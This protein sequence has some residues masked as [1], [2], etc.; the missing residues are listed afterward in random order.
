[1]RKLFLLAF[2]CLGS[3]VLVHAQQ[4]KSPDGN[5][6]V[7]LSVQTDG[8]PVYSLT[9]KGKD[10]VKPSKLGFVLKND[11]VSLLNRFKIAGK[12]LP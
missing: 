12:I 5:L 11:T 6:S 3:L 7:S 8:T 1:M 2:I 4:L 10:V 9:Y